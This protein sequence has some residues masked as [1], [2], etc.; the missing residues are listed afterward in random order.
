V[1]KKKILIIDDS[2]FSAKCISNILEAADFETIYAA[3]GQEGLQMVRKGRPN[4]VLLDVVLPDMSGFDVCR[5]LR[6]SENNNLMPIIMLT[7]QDSQEDKL[8]GLELGADDYIVKPFN[9]REMISRIRNTLRRIDKNR[10]ANPL[11]GLQGNLAIEA[12]VSHK[13][14]KKQQFA[15]IYADIDNF[16]AYN[17]L[18]GFAQGDVAIK[19][20]A[21]I[22]M[23]QVNSL[24]AEDDFIGHIGG[25]DFIVITEPDYAEAISAGIIEQFDYK[26]RQLYTQED[27]ES[28][29]IYTSSCSGE[30]MK[31]PIMSISLAIITNEYR[32]FYSHLQVAEVAAE[33]KKK[34]KAI[35]GSAFARDMRRQLAN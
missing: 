25:D 27:L 22:I 21:D 33:L 9:E 32:S 18:Y 5:I 29:Y 2:R 30:K 6:D 3:T 19:L 11:T 31:F 1:L 23:E 15:A 16:K 17:D 26:I 34:V 28:G 10:G 24:G 13:I 4:L 35:P 7:S 14:E 12:E 8:I 20:T